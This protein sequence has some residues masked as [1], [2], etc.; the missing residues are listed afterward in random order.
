MGYKALAT[1]STG[2]GRFE[3]GLAEEE[4]AGEMLLLLKEAAEVM[5]QEGRRQWS[6]SLFSLELMQQYLAEREVFILWHEGEAAGMF[7]LQY[8]DAAYWGDR[9]DPGFGYLHRLTVRSSY[10]GLELGAKMISFAEAY[11][12]S[13]GRRG[14]RLDCVSHLPTLNQFYQRQGFQFVA[15]QDM[16]GRFVNLYEKT[17][18]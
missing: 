7:T 16:G 13:K 5:E 1:F 4:N 2:R 12:L 14:F 8:G 9:D 10:R 17:F 3:L 18:G 15:E 11:L 6:P